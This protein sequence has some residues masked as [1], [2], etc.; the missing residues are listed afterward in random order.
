MRG[1]NSG[2]YNNPVPSFARGVLVVYFCGR[3]DS[4]GRVVYALLLVQL[5]KAVE[6]R[7]EFESVCVQTS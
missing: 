7:L 3:S 5:S 4:I 2:V 6:R 1:N